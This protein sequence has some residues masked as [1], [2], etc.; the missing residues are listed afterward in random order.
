MYYFIISFLCP[1]RFMPSFALI[2]NDMPLN[3]DNNIILNFEE[4]STSLVFS[5]KSY[6]LN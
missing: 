3:L 5:T 4:T 2:L 1:D 6:L